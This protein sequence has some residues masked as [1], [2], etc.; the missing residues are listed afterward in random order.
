MI[1]LLFLGSIALAGSPFLL[2]VGEAMRYEG[3]I[4]GI[5]GGHTW[6]RVSA[7]PGG[8]LI[9]EAGAKSASWYE[10]IYQVDDYVR[11]TWTP[12]AGSSRYESR[13]REG[14]FHQDQDM[15]LSSA[16]GFVV[17]RRQEFD[18]GWRE[19]S[20]DYPGQPY[21]EDPASAIFQLRQLDGEGPWTFPVFSGEGT[22]ELEVALEGREVVKGTPLGDVT[23]RVLSLQT[24]HRGGWE[25]RGA[26]RVYITDDAR[27]VPLRFVVKSSIGHV[28][29][30]LVE[31]HA[32]EGRGEQ[33]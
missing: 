16:A 1:A 12:G 8:A 32:P 9:I 5:K 25:Q 31:Y 2:P 10:A 21:V 15:D 17:I 7:G 6:T 26:F 24:H 18:D 4:A 14:N 27:R 29:F 20:T 33:R 11:S 19:W 13:F 23:C 3:S 22:W 28:R 30:E